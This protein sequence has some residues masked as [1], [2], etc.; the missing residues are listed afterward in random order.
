VRAS[1]PRGQDARTTKGYPYLRR[2]LLVQ[3]QSWRAPRAMIGFE[4]AKPR[5]AQLC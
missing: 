5:V 2:R 3:T 4:L 1:C